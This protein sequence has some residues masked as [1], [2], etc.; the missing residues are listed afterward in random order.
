MDFFFLLLQK[1][2]AWSHLCVE[3][4]KVESME[5]ESRIRLSGLGS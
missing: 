4:K 5:A 2:D 1:I 3:S